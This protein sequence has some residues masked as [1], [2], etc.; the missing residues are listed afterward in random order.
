MAF[1]NLSFHVSQNESHVFMFPCFLARFE[2]VATLARWDFGPVIIIRQGAHH[3]IH[4]V[5]KKTTM[6]HDLRTIGLHGPI[7]PYWIKSQHVGG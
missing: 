4:H 5:E 3:L 2:S 7:T 6:I 1:K